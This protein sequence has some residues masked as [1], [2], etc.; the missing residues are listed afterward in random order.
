MLLASYSDPDAGLYHS[1]TNCYRSSGW[2]MVEDSKIERADPRRQ[3][4]Q[5]VYLATWEK[6]GDS[7]LVAYW[8]RL[9]DYTLFQRWDMFWVRLA[10]RGQA[11]WPPMVKV[12]LQTP[13]VGRDSYHCQARIQDMVRP[14]PT[15]AQPVQCGGETAGAGK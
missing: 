11:T 6:R 10:M 4:P 14:R 9:G 12:L 3:P 7:I 1:P 8:Y 2:R 13:F 15:V 5:R